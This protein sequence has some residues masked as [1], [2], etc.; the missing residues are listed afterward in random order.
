MREPRK[1][2]IV[3]SGLP[4]AMA[5]FFEPVKQCLQ[6]ITGAAPGMAQIKGLKPGASNEEIVR[7]INEL[8]ARINA[9]GEANG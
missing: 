8:V 7:K 1:P 5:K 4:P 9:S 3:T 2:A 6:M